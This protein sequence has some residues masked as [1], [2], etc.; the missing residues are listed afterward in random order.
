MD[1]PTVKDIE[2]I[3]ASLNNYFSAR[4][5]VEL[6]VVFGFRARGDAKESNDLDVG[7]LYE[8]SPDLMTIG[9]DVSEIEHLTG[10]HIDLVVLNGI[11]TKKPEFAYN[12][13]KDMRFIYAKES[14]AFPEFRNRCFLSY[15]DFLPV[16]A[17]SRR[18]MQDRIANGTW[19]KPIYAK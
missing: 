16:I 3:I 8:A 9:H 7:V 13:A 4:E 14:A 19:G 6:A 11:V 5:D 10:I 12:L 2:T 18:Q 17:Q 1:M 15:F